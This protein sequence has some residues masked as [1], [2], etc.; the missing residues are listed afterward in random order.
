[1]SSYRMPV[2]NGTHLDTRVPRLRLL[3]SLVALLRQSSDAIDPSMFNARLLREVTSR[4][5]QGALGGRGTDGTHDVVQ[6]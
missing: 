6:E 3:S 1:M 5:F 2:A 4:Y